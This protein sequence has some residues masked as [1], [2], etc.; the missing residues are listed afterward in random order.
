MGLATEVAQSVDLIPS[1]IYPAQ[2]A[3]PLQTL[4]ILSSPLSGQIVKLNFVHGLIKKGQVIAEIESPELLQM[5]EDLLATLSDLKIYQQNLTR[6]R[7]LN[8]SGVSS[9]K[10]LQQAL[11]EV[12]KSKL[13]KA[14]LEKSLLFIG[15]ADSA[16][17]QLKK[18]KQ[19]QPA[20]LQIKSPIDGQ[21]FDLQVRLGER[22]EKNQTIIS[23]GETNP[24][25][26]VVRVPVEL[27]NEIKPQ[28]Q[29]SLIE[30]KLMGKV[31]HI[32]MM[33]DAMTQSVDVHIKVQN[34]NNALRSGQLFKIRFLAE[35][36][37]QT[38][39]VSANAISQYGGKTV[40]FV[41]QKKAIEVLPIQVVTITDKQLYFTLQGKTPGA[42]TTYIKGSTAIKAALDASN[43]SDGE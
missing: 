29:V 5:Q 39:K 26:L 8:Q 38:Y 33:V 10:K 20:N 28:Q 42:L 43:E 2:A 41:Q 1:A 34:D 9:T 32:D 37:A 23:M 31:Q 35:K 36:T 22:V 30:K 27:A 24:I 6:A 11:A 13:K 15:M 25:I 17:E 16:I 3:L 19:L 14:Q 4:R 7:K 18:T 12:S 40:I 21:L